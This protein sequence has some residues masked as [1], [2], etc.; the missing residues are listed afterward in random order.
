MRILCLSAA[1]LVLLAACGGNTGQVNENSAAY[2]ETWDTTQPMY[3]IG[4]GDQLEVR[5]PYTPE[6]NSDV[7]V[8]PDGTISLALLGPVPAA[9][10]EPDRLAVELETLY[11]QDL[12]A[13]LVLVAPKSFAS[14][15]VFV[16]GEVESPGIYDLPGG[17]IG[18]LEAITLAGGVTASASGNNVVIIR[19]TI[20]NTPMM[21]TVNIN[22]MI[23]G[24]SN[25]ND[26]PLQRFDIVYVPMTTGAKISLFVDQ[27][28]RGIIPI[29]PE[30]TYA[31][32]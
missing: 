23:K 9:G 16:G 17:R 11:A 28:I 32:Q 21:R 18:V 7:T 6:F 13:P 30:F 8:A 3:V 20:R 25:G 15:K 4:A 12:Q 22:D 27:Y 19:R 29:N 1:L 26:V 2:F 31:V 24:R 5:L 14:Q 10:I